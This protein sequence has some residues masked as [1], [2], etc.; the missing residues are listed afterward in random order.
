[1]KLF[2][3]LTVI[4]LAA[5]S[6]VAYLIQPKPVDTRVSRIN[7][8][9]QFADTDGDGRVTPE[10]RDAL[11]TLLDHDGD[12]L[13]TIEESE[14]AFPDQRD[15][16]PAFHRNHL[17]EDGDGRVLGREFLGVFE[18]ADRNRDGV[19]DDTDL[20]DKP[21]IVLMWAS[22]DNPVRRE[23]IRLFNRLHPDYLMQLDPQSMGME[24]IIVQCLAHVGPDLIDCYS[25]Y[26]LSAWV[27]SGIALD[28]TDHF[29]EK[30]IDT[31][32]I[33]PSLVPLYTHRGRVYGSVNNAGSNAV[34]FN[35]TLFDEAGEPYPEDDWTWEECIEIAKRLTKR[36]AGGQ[37]EQY[38]IIG[39]WDP[40]MAFAQHG[41]SYFTPEGTRCT[42]D[43]EE[44]QE[45]MQFL[46]DLIYV[47]HVMPT[48]QAQTALASAG[49][50]GAGELSLF[51]AGKGALALAGRWWLCSLRRDEYRHLRLG[52]VPLPALARSD[53]SRHR[54]NMGHGKA[55][56]VNKNSPNREG[57]L[58]FLEFLH[59]REWS[60]LINRQADALGPVRKH[61]YTD[62]FLHNPEFP[63][64]DYNE[65]WRTAMEES[66][67]EQVSPYVNGQTVD[68]VMLR[69][70]DMVRANIK[71][72][73][74]AMVDAAR[75]IN[76]EIVKTLR[77]DPELRA[78]YEQ[79]LA[80]GARAAW[81]KPEDAP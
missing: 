64:E 50:W 21:P 42:L 69:Q 46:Q 5:L 36:R 78:E 39:Y 2:F 56:I 19:V 61:S 16:M 25:G 62:T 37:I 4:L 9:I 68:R 1:M 77:R 28:V 59:S 17:D 72:G 80:L 15:A 24:K 48:P 14:A 32:A 11:F 23:Q 7:L 54:G 67:P 44:G 75:E 29:I 73:R 38:G 18:G 70:T 33:W 55:T 57:A 45:A 60:E 66:V 10:E 26:Q 58:L 13:V 30:G 74:Q 35:K 81:D 71:T 51:G 31:G 41:A 34:W 40:K 76:E 20:P 52:A 12:G 27:R 22:D 43:S 65:V 3:T 53:G 79:A 8:F 47:H 6:S 49:G 63:G